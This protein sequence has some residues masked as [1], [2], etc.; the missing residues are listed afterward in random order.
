MKKKEIYR[1]LPSIIKST[2]IISDGWL[3]GSSI[4]SILENK[5]VTDYDI[6]VPSKSWEQST[7]SLRS[8]PFIMNSFGGLKFTLP[9]G[10][11]FIILDIW[12]DDIDNILKVGNTITYAFNLKH[13]RL[14][15]SEE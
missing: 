1:K 12:P 10:D 4:K 2:L 6:I 8:Y 9:D 14:Y 3:I 13:Q 5:P 7:V 15:K 11:N